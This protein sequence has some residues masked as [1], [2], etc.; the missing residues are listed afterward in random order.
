MFLS[1]QGIKLGITVA[2]GTSLRVTSTVNSRLGAFVRVVMMVP[3]R[4]FGLSIIRVKLSTT[5]LL[6]CVPEAV[7]EPVYVLTNGAS[8]SENSAMLTLKGDSSG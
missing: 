3:D 5:A 7:K 1:D 8:Q 4:W 6:A 2:A